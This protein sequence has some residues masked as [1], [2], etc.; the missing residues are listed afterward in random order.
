MA[1]RDRY[2]NLVVAA[3]MASPVY[4]DRGADRRTDPVSALATYS[5]ADRNGAQHTATGLAAIVG[6]H[7]AIVLHRDQ[8]AR[9]CGLHP[10]PVHSNLWR[11][12]ATGNP[13]G[14]L[15]PAEPPNA[16]SAFAGYF[17][18]HLR[19]NHCVGGARWPS[20]LPVA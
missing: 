4:L 9:G 8:S 15:A 2:G 10:Q 3:R 6:G 5:E 1:E 14:H 11:D 17:A 20:G 19:A 12:Y 16:A 18:A 13:E 7:L